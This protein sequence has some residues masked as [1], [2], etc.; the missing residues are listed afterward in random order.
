MT[1]IVA[2]DWSGREKGAAE[3]I[4]LAIVSDGG[5]TYLD[6]GRDRQEI[7]DDAIALAKADHRTVV[8]LDF[9][10]GLPAWYAERE[11]WT[12]GREIWDAMADRA[13]DLLD[14][15]EPP[16]WGRPGTKAQSLGDPYRG[17]E[18]ALRP[19]PKSVFQIGGAGA[20]GTGSLRGMRHLA[21]LSD[22]GFA[23]WP[24]DEPGWPLAVEIFPRLFAPTVVKNRHRARRSFLAQSFPTNRRPFA[25]A[26]PDR[27]TCSTPRCRRSRWPGTSTRS[28]RCRASS[29]AT[30]G[31]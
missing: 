2:I 29:P 1:Q 6:N 14:A 31:A 21:D 22:A 30:V 26:P 17:T 10:F 12:S 24:F 11:G 5:L 8:G 18:E 25:S 9:A 15:C 27:T 20:V 19:R 28:R 4:W 16:F 7:I 23:V 3:M 13:D